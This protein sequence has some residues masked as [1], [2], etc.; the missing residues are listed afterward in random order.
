MKCRKICII[1]TT[2]C[3]L[4]CVYCYE[5]KTSSAFNLSKV[6]S[7]LKSVYSDSCMIE[8]YGGEPFLAFNN[9]VDI[10]SFVWNNLNPNQSFCITTNG[11]LIHGK[12]KQWVNCNKQRITLCLS[13]DGEKN[14]H[15]INRPG[16]FD[17]IDL[18]FILNLK[19]PVA[20]M[21]LSPLTI[22][23]LY[24]NVTYL[25][26]LGFHKILVNI[27]QMQGWEDRSFNVFAEQMRE[28]INYYE[29]NPHILP[30]SLF[31]INFENLDACVAFRKGCD[32]GDEIVIDG[33][34]LVYPCRMLIP[35][36]VSSIQID[37][38]SKM[39]KTGFFHTFVSQKCSRCLFLK[40][41]KT[42]YAANYIERHSLN[43]R[44]MNLC[45]FTKIRIKAAAILFTDKLLENNSDERIPSTRT[46]R[47]VKAILNVSDELNKINW[48]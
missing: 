6:T 34:G 1:N 42:C 39:L 9:L 48:L 22:D 37:E 33:D 30:C 5:K 15:D 19:N 17:E 35:T 14:S 23:T 20:K 8:I 31:D 46:I 3:N 18:N 13:I 21:T 27:A 25:H 4:S 11:T 24:Q 41:C 16:S 26:K 2:Q 44:D 7:K 45:T 29:V 38:I 10:C 12:V 43:E 32:I 28:L 47:C 36:V 40:I